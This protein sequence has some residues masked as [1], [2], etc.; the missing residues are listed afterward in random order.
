MVDNWGIISIQ[1]I[2]KIADTKSIRGRSIL[3]ALQILSG[4]SIRQTAE[5]LGVS[6]SAVH[7]RVHNVL[8]LI[9]QKT[10]IKVRDILRYNKKLNKRRM[11]KCLH[12]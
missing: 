10:Y 3:E 4:L 1:G 12:V 5:A 7:Y 11:K 6:K 8:P 2:S 9:S